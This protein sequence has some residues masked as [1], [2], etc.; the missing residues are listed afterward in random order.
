MKNFYL[1]IYFDSN[2]P[3]IYSYPNGIVLCFEPIYVGIGK[4]KR[5]LAHMEEAKV[6]YKSG[7]QLK[8][9][10]IRNTPV[11]VEILYKDISWFSASRLERVF[12]K[13]IGRL[14]LATG[15]LTNLTDGGEGSFG[16]FCS[17]KTR[18]AISDANKGKKAWNKGLTAQDPRVQKYKR[19]GRINSDLTLEKMSESAKERCKS[20]TYKESFLERMNKK[21]ITEKRNQTIIK[22]GSFVNDNNPRW[23]NID[24]DM[25]KKLYLDD[26]KTIGEISKL[27]NVSP[28]TIIKR[29]KLLNIKITKGPRKRLTT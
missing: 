16:R 14:N 9:N 5:Y 24:V 8:L 10:K 4:G 2:K 28:K 17:E 15:P 7:N 25:I 18:Q 20:K 1:Y 23:K 26:F 6:N 12:I 21:D 13:N 3:G 19:Y 29:L 11:H 22:N 27:F